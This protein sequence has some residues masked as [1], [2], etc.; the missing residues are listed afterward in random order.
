[1]ITGL[2]VDGDLGDG[3]L[4]IVAID[5][6][7]ETVGMTFSSIVLDKGETIGEDENELDLDVDNG[8]KK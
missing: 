4:E 2:A 7:W 5:G 6:A 8:G 3:G 1:L